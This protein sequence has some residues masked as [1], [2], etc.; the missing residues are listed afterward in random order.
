MS[1]SKPILASFTIRDM[2]RED[3]RKWKIAAA[4][5]GE[6]MEEYAIR[7]IRINAQRDLENMES[8]LTEGG[9]END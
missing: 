8:S 9:E 5:R 1:D 4:L 6:S 3:H 2:D 7:V